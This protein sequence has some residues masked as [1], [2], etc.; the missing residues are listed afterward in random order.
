MR[1]HATFRVKDGLDVPC[2][3]IAYYFY[4]D[5]DS[6]PLK[7]DEPK[8]RTKTVPYI[9]TLIFTPAYDPAIYKDLQLFM[10]YSAP[11]HGKR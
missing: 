1:V 2:M 6:T 4:D 9:L 7:T 11:K 3:L 8:Y 5:E 10:P